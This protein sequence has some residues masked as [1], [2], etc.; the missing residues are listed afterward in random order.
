LPAVILSR[1]PHRESRIWYH[2]FLLILGMLKNILSWS[3][4]LLAFGSCKSK[5]KDIIEEAKVFPILPFIQGEVA[6]V[7]TSLYTILE[8]HLIDS[9]HTDTIYRNRQEFKELARD[10]LELPA[11]TDEKY[12]QRFRQD[13]MYDTTMA[14]VIVV[15]TPIDPKNEVI[16]RQELILTPDYG[17]KDSR[18][19]NIIVDYIQNS[20]DSSIQKKMLWN[21]HRSFIITT[22]KQLPGKEEIVTTR[23]VVWN[24]PG[25]Q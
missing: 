2:P 3:L 18:V 7:D 25:N 16:Q 21:A 6:D 8:L 15:C 4:L 1:V 13:V 10:F 24:D 17:G 14:K 22:I 23:K 19:D 20:R 11:L 12:K 5:K 9:T